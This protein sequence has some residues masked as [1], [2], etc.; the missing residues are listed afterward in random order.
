MLHSFSLNEKF[1]KYTIFSIQY[2]VFSIQYSIL[3]TMKK[4]RMKYSNKS[5][6]ISYKKYI[7][8][9]MKVKEATYLIL[10]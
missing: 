6:D 4:A 5:A 7:E 2:S 3:S 8:N 9:K 10:F 1:M